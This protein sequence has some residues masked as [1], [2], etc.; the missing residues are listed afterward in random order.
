MFEERHRFVS[1]KP[2]KPTQSFG[3]QW[4]VEAC[5]PTIPDPIYKGTWASAYPI[6]RTH[7]NPCGTITSWL[8]LVIHKGDNATRPFQVDIENIAEAGGYHGEDWNSNGGFRL[9]K[10]NLLAI[11]AG[12]EDDDLLHVECPDKLT[13]RWFDRHSLVKMWWQKRKG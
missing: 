10:A 2:G 6:A 1:K 8:T 9:S 3:P 11:A 12:M 7:I 13:E 4:K 5:K